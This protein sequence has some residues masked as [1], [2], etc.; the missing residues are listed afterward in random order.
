MPYLNTN[1]TLTM[2]FMGPLLDGIMDSITEFKFYCHTASLPQWEPILY[3]LKS[4]LITLLLFVVNLVQ[5]SR[6]HSRCYLGRLSRSVPQWTAASH[7]ANPLSQ[8]CASC[9]Q[10]L[11]S[12]HWKEE[13][14]ISNPDGLLGTVRNRESI[15]N[16][17]AKKWTYVYASVSNFFR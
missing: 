6:P 7:R 4:A 12:V 5:S 3:A 8:Y 10:G 9:P 1:Q 2:N 11:W 16:V 14:K 15:H 17:T 13:T